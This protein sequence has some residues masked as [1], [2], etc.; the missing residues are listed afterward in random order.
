MLV[1]GLRRCKRNKIFGKLKTLHSHGTMCDFFFRLCSTD[2]AAA[3]A[4][5]YSYATSAVALAV[6]LTS[7][8]ST[9]ETVIQCL[10]TSTVVVIGYFSLLGR[11]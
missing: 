3:A 4:A 5:A 6:K 9:S 7:L 11:R 2:A 10:T 8:A 1:I